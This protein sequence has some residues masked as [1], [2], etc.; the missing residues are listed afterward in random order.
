MP[1]YSLIMGDPAKTIMDI[2]K[3]VV[4]GKGRLYPWMTRFSKGMPWEKIGYEK[5]V[6]NPNK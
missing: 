1:D 3:Y 5:W 4:L 2:R 6:C